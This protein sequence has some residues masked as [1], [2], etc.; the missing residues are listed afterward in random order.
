MRA[1]AGLLVVSLVAHVGAQCQSGYTGPNGGPCTACVAGKY[2]SSSGSS[3]CSSCSSGKYNPAPGGTS[4]AA[5]TLCPVYSTSVSASIACNCNRGYTGPGVYIACVACAAG[6]YKDTSGSANCTDCAAGKVNREVAVITSDFCYDCDI[7]SL[8][9]SPAGSGTAEG[10]ICK[11]GAY[12][13]A[14]WGGYCQGCLAGYYKDTIGNQVCTKCPNATYGN[15][16]DG[17]TACIACPAYSG[18]DVDRVPQDE[19]ARVVARAL[20]E[21]GRRCATFESQGSHFT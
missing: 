20:R 12:Y 7:N 16:Y 21:R 9:Q 4:S 14:D 19:R 8:G 13:I 2:K 11:A 17:A 3:A 1:L 5:C 15:A 6:K 18:V 10:C